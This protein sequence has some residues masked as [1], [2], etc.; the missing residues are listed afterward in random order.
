MLTDVFFALAILT[1]DGPV[2]DAELQL[3]RPAI[4]AVAQAE[5]ICDQREGA[6][7]FCAPQDA[8]ETLRNRWVD[9]ADAPHL[10]DRDRFPD[11]KFCVDRCAINRE[12]RAWLVRLGEVNTLWREEVAAEIAAVDL[13][14][15]IWDNLRDSHQDGYW[16]VTRRIALLKVRDLIGEEAFY[17]GGLR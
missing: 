5:E 17:S 13:E 4:L 8:L 10:H 11:R 15:E 9:L 14:Y 1:S 6:Y 12:R 16:I 2:S 3:F 7:L